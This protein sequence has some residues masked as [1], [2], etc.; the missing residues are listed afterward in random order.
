MT[1]RELKDRMKKIRDIVLSGKEDRSDV[2]GNL[3]SEYEALQK[4]Y[5][6]RLIVRA[7]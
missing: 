7:K 5:R 6:N 4:E 3:V 1:S 2:I